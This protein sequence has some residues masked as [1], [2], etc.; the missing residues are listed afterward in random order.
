MCAAKQG[1]APAT[2]RLAG[3]LRQGPNADLDKSN[4]LLRKAKKAAAAET[5]DGHKQ[6]AQKV[7]NRFISNLHCS[8]EGCSFVLSLNLSEDGTKK[9]QMKVCARCRR[10][11]YCSEKCPYT[12]FLSVCHSLLDVSHCCCPLYPIFSFF[13]SVYGFLRGL[14][15]FDRPDGA[16]EGGPQAGVQEANSARV[17]G[18]RK[19]RRKG[20][21]GQAESL[22][23]WPR[24]LVTCLRATESTAYPLKI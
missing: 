19:C 21:R 13:F 2:A 7:A 22:I 9:G 24:S 18:K 12:S 23:K 17:E 14:V 16:L 6:L 20:I 1:N 11:Q 8:N 4:K 3:L 15:D 10:A 5:D